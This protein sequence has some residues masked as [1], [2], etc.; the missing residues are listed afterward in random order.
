MHEAVELLD[1]FDR[2][3]GE[4]TASR[5]LLWE[6]LDAWIFDQQHR[7]GGRADTLEARQRGEK[8]CFGR[9]ISVAEKVLTKAQVKFLTAG[10]LSREASPKSSLFERLADD[11]TASFG[12]NAAGWGCCT[13][14]VGE[15]VYTDWADVAQ[16]LESDQVEPL[17]R[18]HG[19]NP[20]SLTARLAEED[21]V[22]G[23]AKSSGI[24]GGSKG[25]KTPLTVI[26]NAAMGSTCLSHLH[27]LLSKLSKKR[28]WTYVWRPVVTRGCTEKATLLVGTN[29]AKPE[30]EGAAAVDA[31]S[32][33]EAGGFLEGLDVCGALGANTPVK[34][35]GFGVELAIKNMEYKAV[36]DSKVELSE[37]ERDSENQAASIGAV[38]GFLFDTLLARSSG[39]ATTESELL[40][41]RDLLETREKDQGASSTENTLRAW[42]LDYMG[43]Q[44][45]QRILDARD[46]LGVMQDIS[47]TFPALAGSLSKMKASSKL[48][49]EVNRLQ[50]KHGNALHS[51]PE[52]FVNGLRLDKESAH[53]HAMLGLLKG[54]MGLTKDLAQAAKITS[55][56]A[57]LVIAKARAEMVPEES[58]LDDNGESSASLKDSFAPTTR[59]C[60]IVPT[61]RSL[62]AG[63]KGAAKVVQWMNDVE[64]D[65]KYDRFP[66]YL[67]ALFP[68]NYFGMQMETGNLVPQYRKNLFHLVA[69]LDV[70]SPLSGAVCGAFKEVL[71]TG[72]AV[73]LGLVVYSR[74]DSAAQN[75]EGKLT[76]A[77]KLARSFHFLRK[78]SG[79][80]TACA[81]LK[82]EGKKHKAGRDEARALKDVSQV[83]KK[84]MKKLRKDSAKAME[85]ILA[86]D[87]VEEGSKD[88]VKAAV[89][90]SVRSAKLA[91]DLGLAGDLSGDE[92]GLGVAITV[93]GMV[94]SD[95]RNLVEAFESNLALE[96]GSVSRSP[97][98]IYKDFDIFSEVFMKE[99]QGLLKE[100]VRRAR[101][102]YMRKKL[103][104]DASAL[105]EL[106][107]PQ[108]C[109]PRYNVKLAEAFTNA[110]DPSPRAMEGYTVVD[111]SG[112][113]SEIH[114]A[115]Y[116]PQHRWLDTGGK[117]HEASSGY[118]AIVGDGLPG[119]TA[120]CSAVAHLK[121]KSTGTPE[122]KES[123][124]SK[125]NAI[126]S[127]VPNPESGKK[128][129]LHGLIDEVVS[130]LSTRESVSVFHTICGQINNWEVS[131]LQLD[132]E[133]MD[134]K[135]GLWSRGTSTELGVEDLVE[136][137]KA[138]EGKDVKLTIPKGI[139]ISPGASAIVSSNLLVDVAEGAKLG[140][141]TSDLLF[142]DVVFSSALF[143]QAVADALAKAPPSITAVMSA[144][145]FLVNIVAKRIKPP[146]VLQD[147][148]TEFV[149]GV[150]SEILSSC[151]RSCI[152]VAMGDEGE[153]EE[154]EEEDGEGFVNLF[155]VI[156]P[157][158]K[159]AQRLSPLLSFLR[160]AFRGTLTLV[161]W[162]KFGFEDL[163]LKT[164]YAYAVP[165]WPSEEVIAGGVTWPSPLA[166]R[167]TSLP[168][169]TTLSTQLDTPEA[170]LTGATAASLD[171]DNLK[172]ED[173]GQTATTLYAEFEIESLIVS[174][175]CIDST[176]AGMGAYSEMF[177]TGLRLMMGEKGGQGGGT[178]VDTM[179][180]KNHGYFQLKASPGTFDLGMVPGCSSKMFRFKGGKSHRTISVSSFDGMVDLE[181]QVERES[182]GKADV[183]QCETEM[184]VREETTARED[185][186]SEKTLQKS[187]GGWL[188]KLW[189]GG[190]S[191]SVTGSGRDDTLNIFSVASG[192]L[193]ERFLR[194]MFLSVLRNTESKVKFWLIKNYMS[195]KLKK[196]LPLM[197][198]EY[199]FEYE[200]ITYKWPSWVLR[201]T[202]KQRIIWA[203]KILFLDVIFPIHLDRVIY[204]DAD[205]V[206][207]PSFFLWGLSV[208][209]A[210]R[211]EDCWTDFA[212][213]HTLSLSLFP[214]L[215][216]RRWCART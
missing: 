92:G 126:I 212:H 132:E 4:G 39:N 16:M 17:E 175:S 83:A 77:Q 209:S 75:L 22:Y 143:G 207:L 74:D 14:Q 210:P 85:E 145:S 59:L 6:F 78:A 119:W 180:M 160:Q 50:K 64:R 91:E 71:A 76:A 11:S 173:L 90:L 10:L 73:R 150:V 68:M 201:Q 93:N 40:E 216:A 94:S 165:Q 151:K 183:M 26:L 166:A 161:M 140:G 37:A 103:H 198:E 184:A 46:P 197:A 144:S 118:I 32:P 124:A 162:P 206:S 111:F 154:E 213:T 112:K 105:E 156:D 202:E 191:P 102:L 136:R 158:S 18:A 134:A 135:S 34:V 169:T 58:F 214:Y 152:K 121:S 69:F 82:E 179:V 215:C 137:I 193:Y 86:M 66:S 208:V 148:Y 88:S 63:E 174:G 23:G 125:I 15:E 204:V 177:P 176:A 211:T 157:L 117:G 163:P 129:A 80:S 108:N 116:S 70:A 9:V 187:S 189:S 36:D 195:P 123:A 84:Y 95:G 2:E 1:Q 56:E 203:Y 44:A 107:R 194:I 192:H 53:L 188:S 7:A 120:F 147:S 190:A 20:E 130:S 127:I 200:L 153:G 33:A 172:L 115:L 142:M 60:S 42:H 167:F 139:G 48:K 27:P 133:L 168:A 65:R 54:E 164:Y 47:T 98:A 113:D 25:E 67:N 182:L 114:K 87:A 159:F 5:S 155:L 100:E 52:L 13:T 79:L 109:L 57:S 99:I 96:E 138:S 146:L 122:D 178:L 171:L 106:L 19:A 21:H 28:K 61:K 30:S 41:F 3:N 49:S 62:Q 12:H 45:A 43:L 170:W 38:G 181:L 72:E 35:A 110:A 104:Q 185:S 24:K 141:L 186:G 205:Q 101:D 31:I 128:S 149:S 8:A 89:D 29:L 199:G 131:G 55:R 51:L 97:G 81:M 196:V